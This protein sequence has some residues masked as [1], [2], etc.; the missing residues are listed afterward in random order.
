MLSG[1]GG[2]VRGAKR[3]MSGVYSGEFFRGNVRGN[4]RENVGKNYTGWKISSERPEEKI[5]S[6]SPL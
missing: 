3:G 2:I 1:S 5:M 6:D 4:V